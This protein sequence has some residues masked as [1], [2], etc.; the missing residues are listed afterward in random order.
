MDNGKVYDAIVEARVHKS[1]K[2]LAIFRYISIVW[3]VADDVETGGKVCASRTTGTSTVRSTLAFFPPS[4][5]FSPRSHHP[6]RR[7]TRR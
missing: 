5:S 1:E 2:E 4:P 6:A 3:F 7:R